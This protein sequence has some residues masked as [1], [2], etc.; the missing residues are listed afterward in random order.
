[1]ISAGKLVDSESIWKILDQITV[2]LQCFCSGFGEF[3]A[4]KFLTIHRKVER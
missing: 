4:L 1:M 3:L 2:F